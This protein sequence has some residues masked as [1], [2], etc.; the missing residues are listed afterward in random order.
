M[1]PLAFAQKLLFVT[2]L[3]CISAVSSQ[4][5]LVTNPGFE[6]GNFSGWTLID[7]SGLSNVGGDPAFAH[8]GTYHA[9]LGTAPVPPGPSNIGSLSQNIATT[10]GSFYDVS[11][12]LANDIT[13]GLSPTNSF[14]VL[15]N[16]ATIFTLTP[17]SGPFQYT[18][19]SFFN[20]QATNPGTALEFVFQHD[21]DFFRLDD[22][23][24]NPSGVPETGS[25][26]L[27][28]LPVFGLFGLL[29]LRLRSK[30]A[31]VRG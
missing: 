17:N 9:N 23:S 20:L 31:A 10:P 2:A 7:S 5:N 18:N 21:N 15:W 8:S 30:A 14:R 26:I 4:A 13:A 29:H 12:W 3:L 16:G 22:V 25:T 27:M 24:V 1:K 28:V 19:F 11:F 6:T